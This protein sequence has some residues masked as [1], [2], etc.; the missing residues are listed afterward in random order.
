MSREEDGFL[1]RWSRRKLEARREVEP[2]PDPAPPPPE[3]EPA[4][5]AG[6]SPVE[7][8]DEAEMSAEEIAALPPVESIGP[9][10]DIAAFLRKGVPAALRKAALR[11]VWA[12]DP[13]IRD[14]VNEA[15]EYAYDWN[16]PGGVPGT[17]ALLPT[18][19]VEAM[20][21]R[22]F[23]GSP[24][25]RPGVTEEPSAPGP[26]DAQPPEGGTVADAGEAREP[27]ADPTPAQAAI[28]PAKPSPSP[29]RETI[30]PEKDAEIARPRRHGGAAPV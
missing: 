14:Y 29:G 21:A 20:L 17:G 19:D 3:A 11:R 12:A 7:A 22:V 24:S 16:V 27:S 18:D 23:G 15:R 13:A 2:T 10:T 1:S 30:S 6:G 9:E 8:P 28:E 26:V 5:G 25:P 4:T